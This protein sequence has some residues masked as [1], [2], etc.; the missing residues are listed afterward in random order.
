ML[1]FL[2]IIVAAAA[3][4]FGIGIST[5]DDDTFA[6]WKPFALAIA[7]IVAVVIIGKLVQLSPG[8]Y[9]IGWYAGTLLV[10]VTA[11]FLVRYLFAAPWLHSC[12]AGLFF[13]LM[14]FGAG[15]LFSI[16]VLPQL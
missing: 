2:P 12:L 6:M 10:G 9:Y 4:S 14:E 5:R 16:F 3:F 8:V 13:M 11:A 7:L 15:M 1:E